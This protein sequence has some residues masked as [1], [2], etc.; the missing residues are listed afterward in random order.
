[1]N[2]PFILG[3]KEAWTDGQPQPGSKPRFPATSSLTPPAPACCPDCDCVFSEPHREG[4]EYPP[5]GRVRDQRSRQDQG[6]V[7][8]GGAMPREPHGWML[9]GRFTRHLGPVKVRK[10]LEARVGPAQG[11]LGVWGRVGL[12]LCKLASGSFGAEAGYVV[13]TH[14]PADVLVFTQRTY[15]AKRKRPEGPSLARG[16]GRAHR[17]H[18]EGAPLPCRRHPH[19]SCASLCLQKPQSYHGQSWVLKAG[20]TWRKGPSLLQS[21]ENPSILCAQAG[22]SSRSRPPSWNKTALPLAQRPLAC[23]L[24]DRAFFEDSKKFLPPPAS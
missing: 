8:A 5:T 15:W 9:A 11:G 17:P 22:S 24:R 1:M 10:A 2:K 4:P 20:F 12:S 23:L 6:E 18:Q 21:P 13:S 3:P 14:C 16:R 19:I 7:G